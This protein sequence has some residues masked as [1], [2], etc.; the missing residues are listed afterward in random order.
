MI[1]SEV[2]NLPYLV[3]NFVFMID[4]V[5]VMVISPMFTVKNLLSSEFFNC[6]PRN[7]D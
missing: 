1:N 3:I 5:F 7:S 6:K 4:K 2:K